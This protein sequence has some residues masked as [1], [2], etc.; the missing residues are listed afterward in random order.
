[1]QNEMPIPLRQY[2]DFGQ[3]I[4]TTFQFLRQNWRPLFRAI[5]VICLPPGL[6]AGF[7]LGRSL[8]DL[9]RLTMVNAGQGG[10]FNGFMQMVPMI[11][12]YV[13]LLFTIVLLITIVYEYLRAYE[14][15][16]HHALGAADLWKRSI[17]EI[18]NYIGI[19]LLMGILVVIGT[20]LCFFPGVYVFVA[21]S[22]T[23][24]VHAIERKGVIDSMKRSQH[25]IKERWWETFGLIIILGL[26]QSV[27]AYALMIPTM[28]VSFAIG[29]N[30]LDGGQP[31]QEQF[32]DWYTITMALMMTINM[33][34]TML[35]YP[36]MAVALGLK[37]YSLVEEKEGLGLRQKI[38]GFEQA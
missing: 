8:G 13:L 33:L 31:D 6:I 36:I 12:G 32:M 34:V 37:Y 22:L 1:M 5:G 25:L 29:F 38:Q 16:E 19:S 3:L 10:Q 26:I 28:I 7:L 30:S 11:L 2:R 21:L 17:A 18:G 24:I 27:I 4:S 14:K 9:Q 35:T 23:Y 20:M 15:G